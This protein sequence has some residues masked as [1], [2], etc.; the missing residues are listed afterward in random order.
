[1]LSPFS[2]SIPNLVEGDR[3]RLALLAIRAKPAP[4]YILFEFPLG[5]KRLAGN[6]VPPFVFSFI[7]IPFLQ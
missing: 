4:L 2:V 3:T 7:T 5:P 1:M 6:T